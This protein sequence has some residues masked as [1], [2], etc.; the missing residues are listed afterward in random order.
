MDLGQCAGWRLTHFAVEFNSGETYDGNMKWRTEMNLIR[1]LIAPIVIRFQPTDGLYEAMALLE[2]G[3]RSP[4]FEE[5]SK[6]ELK[7]AMRV[8][9]KELIRRKEIFWT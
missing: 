5:S 2:R 6:D 1:R 7:Y 9:A 3:Y 4:K 8:I